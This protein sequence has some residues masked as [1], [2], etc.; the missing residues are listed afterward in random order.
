MK[1]EKK[2]DT[3]I[4]VGISPAFPPS[5]DEPPQGGPI[6]SEAPTTSDSGP[7]GAAV[8]TS[9]ELADVLPNPNEE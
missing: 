3:S 4:D 6:A 2:N 5:T 7:I 1:D 8:S 9:S